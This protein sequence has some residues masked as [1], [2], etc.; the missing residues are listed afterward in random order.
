M[1]DRQ[2]FGRTGDGGVEHPKKVGPGMRGQDHDVI[3][4][5][6]DSVE[7][8][9]LALVNRHGIR[10]PHVGERLLEGPCLGRT[11][12]S[13]GIAV[14]ILLV[15]GEAPIVLKKTFDCILKG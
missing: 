7:S 12:Q 14:S 1:A 8:G 9:S 11:G 10:G 5:H 2:M 15:D 3:P 6:E 4:V 13:L